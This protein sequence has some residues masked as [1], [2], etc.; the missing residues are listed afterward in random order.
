MQID[1]SRFTIL[2]TALIVLVGHSIF[3]ISDSVADENP[4]TYVCIEQKSVGWSPQEGGEFIGRY[5]ADE[6]PFFIKF[7]PGNFELENNIFSLPKIE[8]VKDQDTFAYEY[9]NCDNTFRSFFTK[10]MVLAPDTSRRIV[11]ESCQ[12]NLGL[13]LYGGGQISWSFFPDF[14]EHPKSVRYTNIY[15]FNFYVQVYG[16]TCTSVD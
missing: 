15:S 13:G 8:V 2:G 5:E 7:R 14:S 10:Q 11:K 4:R 3:G 9:S 6:K 12:A 16:G 1:Q